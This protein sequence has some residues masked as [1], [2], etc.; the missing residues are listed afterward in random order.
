MLTYSP[1]IWQGDTTITSAEKYELP[2]AL[3][4]LEIGDHQKVN[5]IDKWRKI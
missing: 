1:V 4:G 5:S 3:C 2:S